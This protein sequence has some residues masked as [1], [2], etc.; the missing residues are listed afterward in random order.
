MQSM[1]TIG[2]FVLIALHLTFGGA[3]NPSQWSDISEMATD[4]ANNIVRDDGWDPDTHVSPHQDLLKDEIKF[5]DLSI[6]LVQADEL[7]VDIPAEDHPKSDCYIDDIFTAFLETDA[8]HG[9]R[10]VPFILH[11]LGRPLSPNESLP[12]DN[13]LSLKKL[14]AEAMPAECQIILGWI[15]DTR[16]LIIALPRNKFVA[17]TNAIKTLLNMDKVT[18][19]ELETLIG[20]LNHAGFIIPLAQHFLGRLRKAL[21]AASHC[22]SIC[23]TDEQRDDLKQWLHF[24]EQAVN[25]ISL[26]LLT[27]HRPTHIGCSDAS[28]HGIGGFSATTGIAWRW[29]IPLKLWW[30]ATLNVLEYLVGYIT[31]WMEIHVGKAPN[32]SCFLSQTDSTL[33]AGWL[34]KS[35]IDD[36]T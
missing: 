22:Q 28:E 8:K 4:L 20:R 24:L 1:V 29:E 14:L 23:L 3:S 16:Q 12:R 27:F 5:E 25:G 11:L 7:A 13:I 19:K 31:L 9:S 15:I 18:H 30:R 26:N 33:A 10:I 35:N 36:W 32:G 6:P 34:R 21:Y 17:W 2:I